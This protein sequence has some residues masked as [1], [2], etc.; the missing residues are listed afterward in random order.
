MRTAVTEHEVK[1]L[2]DPETEIPADDL[3]LRGHASWTTRELDLVATY[4]DTSDLRLTRAGV[5]LRYRSDDGWTV[6]V[7]QARQGAAF[8]RDEHS[9]A[10]G[11]TDP[12]PAAVDFVRGWTRAAELAP[13]ATIFTHRREI[14]V[15]DALGQTVCIVAED[16]VTGE[17]SGADVVRF[18]EIEVEAR[19]EN[20][21][22]VAE[23]EHRLRAVGAG[24][25]PSTPKINRVLGNRALA[26][27][28]L[29][30]ARPLGRRATIAQLVARAILVPVESLVDNDHRVR[31]GDPG[32]LH[33]ARVATRR[34]RS[35]L[36]T[37]RTILDRAW[38]ESLRQELRW[39]GDRLGHVRDADV[40]IERLET[41]IDD[42][43]AEDQGPA[44]QLVAQLEATRDRDRTVLSDAMRSA[45]YTALLDALVDAA[46]APRLQS[47][48]VSTEHWHTARRL[49]RKPW[50]RT[51]E[52]V[53]QLPKTPTNE[54][55]H[56]VRRRA[57]H[58]RYALESVEPLVGKGGRRSIKRLTELQDQLGEQHDATVVID[59]LRHAAIDATDP[60]VA[61]AAGQIARSFAV[62][63]RVHRRHW[64]K[65]W[66]EVKQ[67]I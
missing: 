52:T 56:D 27:P 12:P 49:V 9:F 23:L 1:L 55:L 8:V 50:K 48:R 67:S 60:R 47:A 18:H 45:R 57:K 30:H 43:A 19:G 21:A 34:L 63:E 38:S 35:H 39:L 53:H 20:T 58:A 61:F 29:A 15:L 46:R 6:K 62:N 7:P 25:A 64:R 16:R 22:A 32:G 42:L 14:T 33:N 37:Y 40:M 28:E 51:R 41:R 31:L 26:P 11:D 44:G 59:W 54:Q 4:Y 65:A 10:S 13:V 2:V 5:S 36:R 3:L 24:T 66:R 17:P